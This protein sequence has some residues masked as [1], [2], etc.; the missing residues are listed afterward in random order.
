MHT[1]LDHGPL[2]NTLNIFSLAFNFFPIH[3]F[4]GKYYFEGSC[5]LNLMGPEI[6]LAGVPL[7][8]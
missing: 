7:I 2:M 5:G 3:L 8:I 6:K 1:T 4:V